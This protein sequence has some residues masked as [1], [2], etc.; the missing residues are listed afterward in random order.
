M[1]FITGASGGIGE[2]CARA[3]AQRKQSLLLVARRERMLQALA[4][5][6]RESHGVQVEA[7][8]LDVSSRAA[9]EAFARERADL[10][11]QVKVLVNNAGLAKGLCNLQEGDPG[12]WDVMIDT[13]IKGLLFATRL[14]MGYFVENQ[15]GHIVNLG[16]V[17]GRW[18][19]P[20][21]NVYCATKSAVHALSES[22]RLD[23]HGSGIRV[24]E[25][26]PGM[27]ETDF[28]KVRLGDDAKAKAVYA[29]ANA[30]TAAD[31][32]ETICWV[33]ERPAR[34]N[35]QEVVMYPT[36]QASPGLVYRS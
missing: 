1:I 5:S 17:A 7:F 10:L 27:V 22:M 36:S 16:S 4:Q 32:A 33:V 34:V 20:K 25:I 13:N 23:L 28:S 19:Y 14:V 3:F 21:G 24:T 8:E 11:K 15:S 12:D 18:T 26:S 29:G 2:A 31:I 35:I 30:L 6:L 9:V